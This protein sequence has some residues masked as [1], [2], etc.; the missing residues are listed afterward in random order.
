[1]LIEELRIGEHNGND[2]ASGVVIHDTEEA[3]L[4]SSSICDDY[5]LICM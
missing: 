4:H 1:M 3:F 5:G 2:P